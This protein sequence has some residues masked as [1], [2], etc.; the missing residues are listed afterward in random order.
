MYPVFFCTVTP[1]CTVISPHPFSSTPTLTLTYLRCG[2]SYNLTSVSF[3]TWVVGMGWIPLAPVFTP[4]PDAMSIMAVGPATLAFAVT[5]LTAV[6]LS[7]AST[8]LMFPP[9][10]LGAP[11]SFTALPLPIVGVGLMARPVVI[12]KA[13]VIHSYLSTEGCI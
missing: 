10:Q 12:Y 6:V 7:V 1:P 4:I 11:T 13:G 2:G 8:S 5:P 3:H 9:A